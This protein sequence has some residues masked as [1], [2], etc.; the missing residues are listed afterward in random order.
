MTTVVGIKLLEVIVSI[1]P[2]E[3]DIVIVRGT[4]SDEVTVNE[5]GIATLVVEVGVIVPV[6]VLE[7][8]PSKEVEEGSE[9]PE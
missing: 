4:V 8:P 9:E 7:T 3:P 2:E 1:P 5:R 6:F